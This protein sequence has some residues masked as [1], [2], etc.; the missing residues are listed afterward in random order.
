M[1]KAKAWSTDGA[2][3]KLTAVLNDGDQSRPSPR[4]HPK[5]WRRSSALHPESI[6]LGFQHGLSAVLTAKNANI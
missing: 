2:V 6:H 5:T 1:R 4:I 3:C